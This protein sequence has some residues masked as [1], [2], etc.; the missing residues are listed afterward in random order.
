MGSGIRSGSSAPGRRTAN[1][2]RCGSPAS[3]PEQWS[4]ARINATV[5]NPGAAPYRKLAPPDPAH[6]H[7]SVLT[8]EVSPGER[9][10]F[11]Q[12]TAPAGADA[13]TPAQP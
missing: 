1:T 3:Q 11:G 7:Q 12:E 8:A 5:S 10:V 6:A 13:R 9:C 2:L 4:V